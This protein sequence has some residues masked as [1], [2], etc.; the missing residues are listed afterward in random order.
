LP[1][2]CTRRRAFDCKDLDRLKEL[3][4]N[5]KCKRKDQGDGE[6]KDLQ[7]KRDRV[8]TEPRKKGI[9]DRATVLNDKGNP[10]AQGQEVDA[11]SPR[12]EGFKNELE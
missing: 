8:D 9:A 11:S 12:Q 6:D 3:N 5:D 10:N 7:D 4:D 1:D 2:S